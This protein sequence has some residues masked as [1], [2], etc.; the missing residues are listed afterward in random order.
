MGDVSIIAR[1]LEDGHVQYGWSGNGGYFDNVG[2]RLLLWYQKP[3]DVEYLFELGQTKLIGKKGSENG[4]C[5]WYETHAL[6]G[7]GFW[8]SNTERRI[9]SKIM[10]IDYG[11][12]YDLDHK[13]Y[14]IIP[15]PFRI[16]MPLELIANHLDERDYEFAY[17]K[18]IQDQVL[19]YIFTDYLEKDADFKKYLEEENFDLGKVINDIKNE[20]GQLSMYDLHD[21]Y[22]AIWKYFDDWILLKTNEDNTEIVD[23]IV[24]KKEEGHTETNL[25]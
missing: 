1:R 17:L 22:Y 8:L 18:E 9:F 21:K 2:Q 10:F 19:Q 5:S 20:D 24:K 14:Y 23:I 25:W 4:G 3:E 12:F 15:G 16:K 7:E 6:T 11:Y 13:W